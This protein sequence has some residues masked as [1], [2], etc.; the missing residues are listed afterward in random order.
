M[1]SRWFAG[2]PEAEPYPTESQVIA[3]LARREYEAM[4]DDERAEVDRRWAGR[5]EQERQD[6]RDQIEFDLL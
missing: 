5:T 4:T 1:V 3:A 6:V 2:D